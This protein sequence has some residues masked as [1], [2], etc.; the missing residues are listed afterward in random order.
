MSQRVAGTVGHVLGTFPV[1][2][3]DYS[4]APTSRF[5]VF[6]TH[7]VSRTQKVEKIDYADVPRLVDYTNCCEN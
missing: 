2:L 6:Y 4:L 7:Y 3:D 5:L 1:G